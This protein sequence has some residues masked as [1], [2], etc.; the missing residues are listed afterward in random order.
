M[1]ELEKKYQTA[2][3]VIARFFYVI[4]P[5]HLEIE[6]VENG[7]F[8][9]REEYDKCFPE[10]MRKS[11]AYLFSLDE[12]EVIYEAMGKSKFGS[13]HSRDHWGVILKEARE[14][15]QNTNCANKYK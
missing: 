11:T 7:L 13:I 14:I 10:F 6:K 8:T 12:I 1:S 3:D 15:A 2:L 4:I 5:V 9:I